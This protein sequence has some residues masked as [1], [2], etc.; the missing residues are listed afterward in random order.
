MIV[1]KRSILPVFRFNVQGDMEGH[2]VMTSAMSGSQ[3][4]KYL[5]LVPCFG[6]DLE[7]LG[8]MVVRR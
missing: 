7:K 8:P 1:L 2:G 3:I 5:F 6:G 4:S